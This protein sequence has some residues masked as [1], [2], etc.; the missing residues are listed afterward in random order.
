[1]PE[2]P[3]MCGEVPPELRV[4]RVNYSS[5]QPS[6]PERVRSLSCAGSDLVETLRPDLI[7]VTASPF[8]DLDVA[9][10]LSQE[11][12][13]P[14]V[15]DLRDP[16]ALDEFQVAKSR[17]HR[18]I[19]IRKMKQV[20]QS[21]SLV[22]M[23]TP[24][25]CSRLRK[26]F[27]GG[28]GPRIIW[29]TNGYD[30]EDFRSRVP[31]REDGHFLIVHTG[32]LHSEKGLR[33]RR[34]AMP[35]R[36][37]GKV[38]PGVEFLPRSHFYLTKALEQWV[39]QEPE[40]FDDVRVVLAGVATHTDQQIVER[41]PVA[42]MVNF[43]GYLAHRE[44]VRILRQADLLFLPLH[45]VADSQRSSIVPGKTYEYMASGRRILAAVPS[46][47]AREMLQAAGCAYLVEPDDEEGIL[48]GLRLAYSEWASATHEPVDWNGDFVKRF[49][50]RRLTARLAEEL[51]RCAPFAV[52]SQDLH[53]KASDY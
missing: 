48:S 3:S 16:W 45:Q 26:V 18:R 20:L 6:V 53:A 35:Y 32:A 22:V 50:R 15:A 30:E 9:R 51:R 5:S 52:R 47:D 41:S 14:W 12:R 1:V 27:E 21:A 49:E 42:P 23:N 33:Q 2:D 36:L 19:A 29:I 13:I 39:A 25:A 31:S 43:T 38:Q 7:L 40:R 24:E 10:H 17:W 34:R 4:V 37:F 28:V 46:G 11:F 8:E 44:S